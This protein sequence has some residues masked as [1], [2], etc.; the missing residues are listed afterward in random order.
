MN[1]P[2]CDDCGYP[3]QDPQGF[4]CLCSADTWSALDDL[5]EDDLTFGFHVEDAPPHD[6]DDADRADVEYLA[7]IDFPD[8]VDDGLVDGEEMLVWHDKA[9]FEEMHVWDDLD[10]RRP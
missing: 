5:D 9:A 3:L 7:E 8:D 6:D 2:T 10:E 1:T 4:V